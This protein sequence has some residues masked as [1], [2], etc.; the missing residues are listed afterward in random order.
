LGDIVGAQMQEK[1]MS[2]A[3]FQGSRDAKGLRNVSLDR[4]DDWPTAGWPLKV[5]AQKRSVT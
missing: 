3:D 4:K 2:A 5:A 1:R